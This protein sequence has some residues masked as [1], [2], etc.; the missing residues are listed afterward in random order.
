VY[1][2]H[3]LESAA[4]AGDGLD[5]LF[6]YQNMVDF[7]LHTLLTVVI[8]GEVTSKGSRLMLS[9]AVSNAV[10]GYLHITI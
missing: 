8:I 2:S 7:I 3:I 6:K 4:E 1:L 9:K 5:D 10:L